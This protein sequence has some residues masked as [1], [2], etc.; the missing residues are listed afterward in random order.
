MELAGDLY[1][2]AASQ[3]VL[4]RAYFAASLSDFVADFDWTSD[5]ALKGL[6][7]EGGVKAAVTIIREARRR[8]R[9]RMVV[10]G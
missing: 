9:V 7:G 1:A 3:A 5:G 10:N 4:D 6:G 2:E 8:S